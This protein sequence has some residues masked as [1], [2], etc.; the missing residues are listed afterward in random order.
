M[1]YFSSLSERKNPVMKLQRKK[2]ERNPSTI[3]AS[4]C[5]DYIKTPPRE[6]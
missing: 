1:S 3:I 5:I 4:L 2:L 6:I